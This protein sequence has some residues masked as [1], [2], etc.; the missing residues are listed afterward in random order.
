[1]PGSM[2]KV[3]GTLH[4]VSVA[5]CKNAEARLYDR[6]FSCE[7]P[8]EEK[9]RDFRELLNP[10]SLKVVDNVKIEPY[11]A[12]TAHVGDHYQFQRTG[13]FTVDPDST[14]EKIVFN[15][16]ISLKDSWAKEQNKNN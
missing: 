11:L 16:T 5:H 9:D 3:K 10:D 12:E 6:L 8:A 15:R 1:M 4:W 14:A 7:N 13:Y 2:R